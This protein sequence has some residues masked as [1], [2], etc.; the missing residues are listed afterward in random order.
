MLGYSS[1]EKCL[2][3][4]APPQA[5]TCVPV[6]SSL[7]WR[8]HG[9]VLPC[10][11]PSGP[12]SLRKGVGVAH[13]WRPFAMCASQWPLVA[14]QLARRERRELGGAYMA[15]FAMCASRRPV[16]AGKGVG[17]AH[18][19]AVLAMCASGGC[20]SRLAHIAKSAMYAPPQVSGGGSRKGLGLGGPTGLGTKP[21]CALESM[22]S[23]ITL[24]SRIGWA[25]GAKGFGW[26]IHGGVCHVY[27]PVAP[28]PVG[29][30]RGSH[31]SQKAR[32]VC[33]TRR[34]VS[35]AGSPSRIGTRRGH[36]ATL[37]RMMYD[38]LFAV[39][40]RLF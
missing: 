13:T 21:E 36:P 26:R 31:T 30:G 35:A 3:C 38:D 9:A 6:P 4:V 16:V 2:N 17:V 24:P 20:W 23:P 37:G 34:Y 33:A 19:W 8:I 7:G 1:M 29:A 12:S 5:N 11:R 25:K 22:T 28:R 10:V 15:V 32:D 14:A 39:P 18:T 40:E 27:V